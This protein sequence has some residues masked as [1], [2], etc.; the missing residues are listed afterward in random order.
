MKELIYEIVFENY[1]FLYDIGLRRER[2]NVFFYKKGNKQREHYS[3][4]K[5]RDSTEQLSFLM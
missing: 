2:V 3:S 4:S 5:W 1:W